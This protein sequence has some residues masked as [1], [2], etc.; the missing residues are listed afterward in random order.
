MLHLEIGLFGKSWKTLQL[1]LDD[2]VELIPLAEQ[3]LKKELS[4]LMDKDKRMK[5]ELNDLTVVKSQT[6]QSRNE[7]QY[8]VSLFRYLNIGFANR[9]RNTHN[10]GVGFASGS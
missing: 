8:E 4:I 1:Y 5:K 10:A 6:H 2:R 3:E 9:E 7:I